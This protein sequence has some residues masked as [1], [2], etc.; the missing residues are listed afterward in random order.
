[1]AN[2]WVNNGNSDRLYFLGF[3]NHC[4]QWL[5]PWNWR[6]LAPWKKS[7]DRPRQHI[8]KQRHHFSGK[9][10]YSQSCG[11]SSSH[12]WIW[13]PD[14]KEG[15][16]PKNWRFWIVVLEKTLQ[17]PLDSKE[18]QP[19]NPEEK[20]INPEYL[21]EGL[22]LKFQYFGHLMKRADSLEKTLMMGK[23]E[24]KRRRGWQRMK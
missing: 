11:F 13:E 6:T 14:H 19:V 3:Q 4:G 7:Y 5:Q 21:L 15:W 8:K 23:I 22:K 2:R 16:V 17:S 1:M 12:V 9:G 24:S 18:I 10:L 20:E